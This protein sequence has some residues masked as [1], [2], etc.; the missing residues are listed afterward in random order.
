MS[1]LIYANTS[2]AE[3][4]QIMKLTNQYYN[5]QQVNRLTT[6]N[7]EQQETINQ[8]VLMANK[9][10]LT[11]NNMSARVRIKNKFIRKCLK[12]QRGLEEQIKQLKATNEQLGHK[13]SQEDKKSNSMWDTVMSYF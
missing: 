8:L 6:I 12:K 7:K 13:L 9:D 3:N 1:D 10:K 2:V 4:Q 5:E 11:I